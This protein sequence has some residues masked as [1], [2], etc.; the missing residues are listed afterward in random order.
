M[1]PTSTRSGTTLYMSIYISYS[2]AEQA[3]QYKKARV[4]GDQNKE[5]EILFNTDPSIQKSL[6]NRVKGLDD[7]AWS[8]LKRDIMKDILIAKFTQHEDL[9]NYLLSKKDKKIA[10]ANAK[11]SFFCNRTAADTSGS[12]EI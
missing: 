4:A 7:T 11:D 6:G 8:G 9:R 5:Q 2:S 1:S 12:S 3:F 10:E